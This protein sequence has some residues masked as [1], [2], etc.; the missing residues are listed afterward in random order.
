MEKIK[1]LNLYIVLLVSLFSELC[2]HSLVLVHI[3]QEI[4][5]YMYYC[6]QQ[7]RIFNS[8]DVYLVANANA[9]EKF[10]APLEEFDV[11]GIPCE[12]LEKSYH[13]QKFAQAEHLE[14]GFWRYTTERFFYIEELARQL[15]L[16]DIFHIEYDNML[17]VDVSQ[18]ELAI[19]FPWL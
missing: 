7:I 15:Q 16:T 10:N 4:P 6:M 2:A 9:L 11:I 13:H 18:L 12:S 5:A 17:Y 8:C 14:N 1:Y 3:G 19:R